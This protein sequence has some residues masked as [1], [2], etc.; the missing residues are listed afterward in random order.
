[1]FAFAREEQKKQ[2]GRSYEDEKQHVERWW[3]SCKVVL[4]V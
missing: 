1:M 4:E 2:L 3:P